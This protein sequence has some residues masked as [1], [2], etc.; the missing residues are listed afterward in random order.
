M[1]RV[2]GG[3]EGGALVRMAGGYRC[4]KWLPGGD[5]ALG[6]AEGWTRMC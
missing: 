5:V 2:I 4:Q 1:C 3:T 6:V